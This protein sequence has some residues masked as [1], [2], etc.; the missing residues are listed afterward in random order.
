MNQIERDVFLSHAS[1][2]KIEFVRP[3]ASM[4]ETRGISYW[5]DDGE[6]KWGD[7]IT[8]SINE[9]LAHAKYVIVFLSENFLGKNWPESELGAAL[10]KENSSG[11]TVV[12]PIMIADAEAVLTRYPLLR[13]KVYLRWCDPL[14]P[15]ID[16]L[17]SVISRGTSATT[18][19]NQNT[20]PVTTRSRGFNGEELLQ[21]IR[22]ATLQAVSAVKM[23]T[24]TADMDT[25]VRIEN[26]ERLKRIFSKV[27]FLNTCQTNFPG[28]IARYCKGDEATWKTIVAFTRDLSEMATDV[29]ELL[30]EESSDFVV[31]NPDT[32]RGLVHAMRNRLEIFGKIENLPS[33]RS[34]RKMQV[35]REIA[36]A[37]P[38]LIAAVGELQQV[39]R[40]AL[41][42][43]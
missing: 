30:S 10:G 9:G 41:K 4:L 5:L 42:K 8:K 33:K 23:T 3:F 14:G 34:R 1:E 11:Q 28:T 19:A 25:V 37:Y 20:A 12:L 6:I 21:L 16:Q 36:D 26:N 29:L 24:Q 35:L 7:K 13:D 39:V 32:Y 2:D 22:D 31:D 43:Q 27:E 18:L 17:E 40:S 15:M 38:S